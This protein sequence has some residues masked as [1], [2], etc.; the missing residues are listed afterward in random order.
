MS[1]WRKKYEAHSVILMFG[2]SNGILHCNKFVPD[3]YV[4]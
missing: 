2:I 3:I 4:D 1:E